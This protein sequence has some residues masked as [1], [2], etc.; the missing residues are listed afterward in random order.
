[1]VAWDKA[2]GK[3]NTGQRREIQRMSLSIG[4]CVSI[5]FGIFSYLY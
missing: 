4:I 3:Q 2:K 5:R 1:M